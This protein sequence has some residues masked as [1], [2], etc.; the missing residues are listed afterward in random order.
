[1]IVHNIAIAKAQKV[2]V[3]QLSPNVGNTLLELPL[4]CSEP[5]LSEV[6][7]VAFSIIPSSE[8]NSEQVRESR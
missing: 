3:S 5:A 4:L 7:T 6:N 1:M 2:N 8:A